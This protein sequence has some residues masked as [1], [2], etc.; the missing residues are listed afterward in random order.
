MHA[1]LCVAHD[2]RQGAATHVTHMLAAVAVIINNAAPALQ[3]RVVVVAADGGGRAAVLAGSAAQ[4]VRAAVRGGDTRTRTRTQQ[5]HEA[6]AAAASSYSYGSSS[7]CEAQL[8]WAERGR[9]RG[10]LSGARHA[11]H[12]ADRSSCP[13]SSSSLYLPSKSPGV[14]FDVKRLLDAARARLTEATLEP[15]PLDTANS[16]FSGAMI[17]SSSCACRCEFSSRTLISRNA[18]TKTHIYNRKQGP[19]AREPD[20]RFI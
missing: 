15:L 13:S 11:T 16:S 17:R 4:A 12:T 3:L 18:C 20:L 14:R 1:Q 10:S 8:L 5:Q 7:H 2:T 19:T 9:C 6:E